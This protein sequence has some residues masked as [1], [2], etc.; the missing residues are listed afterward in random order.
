MGGAQA[1]QRGRRCLDRACCLPDE[2]EEERK[3]TVRPWELPD[4]KG[5]KPKCDNDRM[6]MAV[7]EQSELDATSFF[8]CLE[9][10]SAKGALSSAARDRNTSSGSSSTPQARM[11]SKTTLQRI[12]SAISEAMSTKRRK[13]A[14]RKPRVVKA[15]RPSTNKNKT[16]DYVWMKELLTS[17]SDENKAFDAQVGGGALFVIAGGCPNSMCGMQAVMFVQMEDET[18]DFW[19]IKPKNKQNRELEVQTLSRNLKGPHANLAKASAK[20]YSPF[21]QRFAGKDDGN[22]SFGVVGGRAY[23]DDR[24]VGERLLLYLV[25]QENWSGMWDS[26]KF[27]E[28]KLCYQKA[29]RDIN[30]Q[31][32]GGPFFARQYRV[33]GDVMKLAPSEEEQDLSAL[34][35]QPSFQAMYPMV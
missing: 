25:W 7:Q 11:K 20:L 30:A 33:E 3:D 34:F 29:S 22:F 12:G 1:I 27:L 26:K 24:A 18:I 31:A 35:P 6:L 2:E 19:W 16:P 28:G 15:T 32:G 9:T 5:F 10:D 17:I 23:I 14:L 13:A 8:S 21:A 4:G